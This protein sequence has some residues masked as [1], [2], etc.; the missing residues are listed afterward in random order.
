MIV[1]VGALLALAEGGYAVEVVD[2]SGSEHL[3]GVD[4]GEIL[5]GKAEIS[6][7]R[8]GRRHGAGGEVS[9]LDRPVSTPSTS[10]SATRVPAPVLEL[11]DVVEDVPRVAARACAGGGVAARRR[12]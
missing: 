5:D 10:V 9:V 1:P 11:V 2:G 6:R 3:V 8:R 12:R 4:V 7:R